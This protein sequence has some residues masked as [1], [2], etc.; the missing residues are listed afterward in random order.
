ML[1]KMLTSI[2]GQLLSE[3]MRFKNA[4]GFAWNRMNAAADGKPAAPAAKWA[5]TA[6][7]PAGPGKKRQRQ[8]PGTA[9]PF[10]QLLY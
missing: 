7:P 2:K 9:A 5:P 8:G 3:K 6:Q 1:K 4:L 10:M